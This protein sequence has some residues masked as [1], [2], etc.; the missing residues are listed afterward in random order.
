MN[1]ISY[2]TSTMITPVSDDIQ[3]NT[4]CSIFRIVSRGYYSEK[5]ASTAVRQ[6]LVAVQV[7]PNSNKILYQ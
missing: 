1:I 4:S 3:V 6:M 2:I 7:S 5:D